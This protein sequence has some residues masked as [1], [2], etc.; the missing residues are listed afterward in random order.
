MVGLI[1]RSWTADRVSGTARPGG[2]VTTAA[3]AREAI[4]D[5]FDEER[6]PQ[7]IDP[8]NG[9]WRIWVWG[10]EV[11]QLGHRFSDFPG[12]IWFISDTEEYTFVV[13]V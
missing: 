7:P 2:P 3:E 6:T 13:P 8:E 1:G 12:Q 11:R 10:P 5:I 4:V 9:I